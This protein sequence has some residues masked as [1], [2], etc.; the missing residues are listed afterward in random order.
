MGT[1][2]AAGVGL[3]FRPRKSDQECGGGAASLNVLEPRTSSDPGVGD[4]S[5]AG[6]LSTAGENGCASISYT[7][8]R[9]QPWR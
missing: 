3:T 9:L 2:P 7:V 5:A 4:V 1:G 8:T 6:L